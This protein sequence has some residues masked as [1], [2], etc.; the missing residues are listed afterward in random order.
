KR[1]ER[2]TI[3]ATND[4]EK[5]QSAVR[6]FLKR[7]VDDARPGLVISSRC[8]MLRKGFASHYRFKAV[9]GKRGQYQ[10]RPEKNE[11][12]DPHDA[13]QYDCLDDGGFEAVTGLAERGKS[14]GGGKIFQAKLQV[15]G[16]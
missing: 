7:T 1:E 8:R 12:S 13:L 9:V 3:A 16:I 15:G 2:I 10:E 14:W 6:Y 4:P 5:R 11:F